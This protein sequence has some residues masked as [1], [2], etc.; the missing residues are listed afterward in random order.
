MIELRPILTPEGLLLWGRLLGTWG[1]EECALLRGLFAE[2]ALPA[3]SRVLLD[4]SEL[5]H[6]HFSGAPWLV[7]LGRVL[8]EEGARVEIAGLNDRLRD[9]LE[10]G[11]ASDGRDFIE[12]HGGNGSPL[13]GRA[14][15]FG[16]GGGQARFGRPDPHGL[17]AARLN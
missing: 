14:E 5:G 9:I 10:L 13:P 2:L 11:A 15:R 1:R 7:E 6:L 3:G 17:A 4:F 16:S 8:E 12:R